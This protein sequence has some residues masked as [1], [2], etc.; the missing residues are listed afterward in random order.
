VSVPPHKFV[1]ADVSNEASAKLEALRKGG[2]CRADVSNE[3]SAKLEAPRE[4]GSTAQNKL[5]NPQEFSAL[6]Y[7]ARFGDANEP[8]FHG[9]AAIRS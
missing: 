9:L 5:L 8:F 2:P 6:R 1:R 7:N 3:A 4:G